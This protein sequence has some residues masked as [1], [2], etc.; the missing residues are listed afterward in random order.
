MSFKYGFLLIAL[1]SGCLA[2]PSLKAQDLS[3]FFEHVDTS[4]T[5]RIVG[6][7]TAEEGSAPH[8]V[9]LSV[10]SIIRSLSCGG[11]LITTQ[12]ILTAAHCIE[13][14]WG[15]GSLVSSYRATVGTNVWNQ[16]G[17]SYA[18]ARNVTHPHYLGSTIKNDIGLLMTSTEVRMSDTVKPIPLSFGFV[19]GGIETRATGWGRIRAGGP[20]SNTLLELTLTTITGEE[21]VEKVAQASVDLDIRAPDIEPHLEL[22]VFHSENHGMC[23]GD[24][25]SALV[26]TDIGGQVGVVS[27]GF[28]CALGAP[29]MFTRVGAFR[30]FIEK[31]APSLDAQDLSIFFDHVDTSASANRIMGGT[32]A[33]EGSA[34]YMVALTG[35]DNVRAYS[36]YRAIVG[37]DYW[38]VGGDSYELERN[39][40]HPHYLRSTIKNDISLLI[41]TTEI[42]LSETVKVVPLSFGHVGA[43]IETRATGWGMIRPYGPLSSRLLELTLT[44]IDG[45][46]CKEK[47]AQAS[48]DFDIPAPAIEPHLELCVFH[49][50]NRGLCSGDSGSP[51]VR[52]D[53]GGQVGIVSW[54]FPCARGAPDMFA[55]ISAFRDF[56]EKNAI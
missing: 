16:G 22:C 38:N 56:I 52:T 23:N 43:G 40:T 24:S 13:G 11:S 14:A 47:V 2:T 39:V 18:I 28:P 7:T 50:L 49:S 9:A 37:T 51:L 26:R 35:G 1:L 3:I 4:A 20:I 55:R 30:D 19:E 5:N 45:E 44:T 25:G 10:G 6:G 32:P 31:H 12:T 8:M 42:R 54:G 41:T 33:E 48:V 15:F 21:C 34:A 27:W 17:A 29:D 46:E 53:I 36:S